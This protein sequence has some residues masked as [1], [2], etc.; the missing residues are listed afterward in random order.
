M[1]VSMEKNRRSPE[2]PLNEQSW[3]KEIKRRCKNGKEKNNTSH[4]IHRTG[5]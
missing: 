4:T 1:P 5:S 2:K 3:W